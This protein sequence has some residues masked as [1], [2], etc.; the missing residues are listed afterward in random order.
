MGVAILGVLTSHFFTFAHL[1][2]SNI[3]T[4][5]LGKTWLLVYIEGFLFLSGFG[6]FFSMSKKGNVKDFYKRRFLRLMV[7]YLLFTV[8]YFIFQDLVFDQ[9]G[10]GIIDFLQ[11]ISTIAYWID[12]NYNGLWY[13]AITVAL[14]MIY[15]I[16][17]KLLTFRKSLLYVTV[18]MTGI[19]SF[20]LWSNHILG[21]L[22]PSWY[23]NH[24][25]GLDQYYLFFIGVYYAYLVKN[26]SI[27]YRLA[28]VIVFI[29]SFILQ[30]FYPEFNYF[31]DPFKKIV[32]FMPMIAL[33]FYLFDRFMLI[34]LV[35]RCIDWMGKYSLELY[36]LHSIYFCFFVR[37]VFDQRMSIIIGLLLAFLSCMPLHFVVEK[38][39][40]SISE[41]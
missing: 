2:F 8:P 31:Y 1:P 4:D 30:R 18:I 5:L 26:K 32:I 19:I 23:L 13:I 41:K 39:N 10:G 25:L 29:L 6:I 40:N 15:P 35:R 38:I 36:I 9:N 24:R 16:V 11:H 37:T 22:F 17:H 12:G 21:E 7:P 28:I 3:F 14:Y 34:S 33:F 27:I 20:V